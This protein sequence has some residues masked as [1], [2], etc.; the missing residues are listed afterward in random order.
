MS[1]APKYRG[2][3]VKTLTIPLDPEPLLEV[4]LQA[5]AIMVALQDKLHRAGMQALKQCL[6][7]IAKGEAG[8]RVRIWRENRHDEV[9]PAIS[10]GSS[11]DRDHLDQA[12]LQTTVLDKSAEAREVAKRVMNRVVVRTA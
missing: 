11:L 7:R 6:V 2:S 3:V 8:L 5:Q 1:G 10:R 9:I 12:P 4:E